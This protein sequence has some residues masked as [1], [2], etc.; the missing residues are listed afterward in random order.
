MSL[1]IKLD[2]LDSILVFCQTF[3]RINN[4]TLKKLMLKSRRLSMC[5][6]IL[7]LLN[8]VQKYYDILGSMNVQLRQS[9]NLIIRVF[10]ESIN[11]TQW[12]V[13]FL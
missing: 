5:F 4:F 11:K 12:F 3:R 8:W 10:E 6:F 9:I 7:F 13:I 2:L 1:Y